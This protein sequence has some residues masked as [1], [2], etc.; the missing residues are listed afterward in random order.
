MLVIDL[1]GFTL[2][3]FLVGIVGVGQGPTIVSKAFEEAIDGTLT[4]RLD[5]LL[6]CLIP[7]VRN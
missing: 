5:Y 2:D 7:A 4:V 6:I 1:I 3:L